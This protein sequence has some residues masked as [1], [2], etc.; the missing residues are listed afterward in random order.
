ML[1]PDTF[2]YM[3]LGT[4]LCAVAYK[5]LTLPTLIR[6]DHCDCLSS[7]VNLPH[8][9]RVLIPCVC[10]WNTWCCSLSHQL[11]LLILP[12]TLA[13]P[14]P[15][16]SPPASITPLSPCPSCLPFKPLDTSLADAM[17]FA[18]SHLLMTHMCPSIP[19]RLHHAHHAW[20]LASWMSLLRAC[21]SLDI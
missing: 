16:P 12:A 7:S 1:Y 20:P 19:V 8:I 17:W 6:S 2:Q 14:C 13:L 4:L 21:I 5:Y 3:L 15:Y 9:M 11:A 10:W 18:H